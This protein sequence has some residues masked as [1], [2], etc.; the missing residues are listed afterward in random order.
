MFSVSDP[1]SYLHHPEFQSLLGECRDRPDELTARLVMADWLDEW[2]GGAAEVAR[3]HAA[4]ARRQCRHDYRGRRVEL[5][6]DKKRKNFVTLSDLLME[7]PWEYPGDP[8]EPANRF[9]NSSGNGVY[10]RLGLPHAVKCG[11]GTFDGHREYVRLW[12]LPVVSLRIPAASGGFGYCPTDQSL[13]WRY[14]RY[15]GVIRG[16]TSLGALP[17]LVGECVRERNAHGLPNTRFV[18]VSSRDW[19]RHPIDFEPPPAE[20]EHPAAAGVSV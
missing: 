18:A 8:Y 14:G 9:T 11:L 10:F 5:S 19:R 3:A 2:T 16:T 12:Q 4:F 13:Y 7:R 6:G 20:T 1:D 17:D 15:H